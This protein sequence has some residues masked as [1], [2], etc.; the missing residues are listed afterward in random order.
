M[1]E[2]GKPRAIERARG[3]ERASSRAHIAMTTRTLCSTSRASTPTCRFVVCVL[4][5]GFRRSRDDSHKFR[6]DWEPVIRN[7]RIVARYRIALR[8]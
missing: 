6:H 7:C 8:I 5:S 2:P 1:T 3:V 4:S